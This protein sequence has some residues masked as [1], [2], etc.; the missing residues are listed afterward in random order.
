MK[1]C[2]LLWREPAGAKGTEKDCLGAVCRFHTPDGDCAVAT[3]QDTLAA[4]ANRLAE[5]DERW[6]NVMLSVV[7]LTERIEAALGQ[8]QEAVQPAPAIKKEPDSAAAESNLA[9]AQRH[10]SDGIS[11]FNAGAL[12]LA[13]D[14]FRRAIEIHPDFVEGHN[15][16]GLAETEL[17]NGAIAIRHFQKAIEQNPE[18]AASYTN[19]GYVYYLQ[20]NF[21]R[22][23]AM[24]E[25]ALQRA[26]ESSV[27]WTNLGNAYFK[28]G[29]LE[30]ARNAWGRAVSLDPNNSK[31][32]TNLAQVPEQQPASA[33]SGS[34]TPPRPYPE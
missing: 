5:S 3:Q 19:L 29:N 8:L 17:G 23:I 14:C 27:A 20:R 28:L 15:N 6:E 2:P 31:A 4:I 22:A 18:L 34:A 9:S 16:L 32:A 26:P 24:Y 30:Q 33:L 10:N 21:S 7:E 25:Q 13:R 11:H 1:I 12:K